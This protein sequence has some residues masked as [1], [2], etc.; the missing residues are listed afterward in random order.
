MGGHCSITSSSNA[1]SEDLKKITAWG[2]FCQTGTTTNCYYKAVQ[3]SLSSGIGWSSGESMSF[4]GCGIV[5][6]PDGSIRN[7]INGAHCRSSAS[8]GGCSAEWTWHNYEFGS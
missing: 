1:K 4:L 3:V 5:K 6:D 2:C 8:E 7:S